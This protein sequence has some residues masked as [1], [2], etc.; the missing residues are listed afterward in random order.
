M[1]KYAFKAKVWKY[2]GKAG[3]Y[4]VTLPKRLSVKI[5][6]N[7]GLSEE[8]WGRLK[9]SARV[10]HTKWNTAIW[11]DTKAGSYLLP[12]KSD[13]RKKE[14]IKIAASLQVHLQFQAD[15]RF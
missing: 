13:V 5:R 15:S 14:G 6:K 9:T 12:L 8:G 1:V 4:F 10:G 3:W 11:F 7:H 2:K